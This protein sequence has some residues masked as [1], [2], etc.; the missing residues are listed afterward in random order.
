MGASRKFRPAWRL[1]RLIE[2]TLE[3]WWRF[4]LRKRAEHTGIL[5]KWWSLGWDGRAVMLALAMMAVVGMLWA[6]RSGAAM[7][8]QGQASPGAGIPYGLLC[9]FFVFSWG[10]AAGALTTG[11][12]WLYFFAAPLL[13]GW[14]L[15]ATMANARTPAAI[16]PQLWF[17]AMGFWMA[18]DRAGGRW[19]FFWLGLHVVWVAAVI[20]GPS[21]LRARWGWTT[22][23]MWL[24]LGGCGLALV[25]AW[26]LW[27]H[28]KPAPA[29]GSG[30]PPFLLAWG[31]ATAVFGFCL[32][33]ANARNHA[34][35][36]E[37]VLEL[38][39]SVGFFGD[40][41]WIWI[42]GGFAGSVVGLVTWSSRAAVRGLSLRGVLWA[43]PALVLVVTVAEFVVFFAT[44]YDVA[45]QN[46]VAGLL[47]KENYFA[48]L[49]HGWLGVV[50]LVF[51]LV[52]RLAG[53]LRPRTVLKA[54]VA[55]TAAF[56]LLA[57]TF[58]TAIQIETPKPLIEFSAGGIVI[59]LGIFWETYVLGKEAKS[60]TR[61]QL[62][63]QAA[64]TAV[65]LMVAITGGAVGAVKAGQTKSL[66]MLYGIIHLG[67]LRWFS[68]WWTRNED[69]ETHLTET[70]QAGLFAGG[71]LGCM[72]YLPWQHKSV[73]GL[74]WL[75]PV[76]VAAA[77]ILSHQRR[78]LTAKGAAV[79]GAL[80]AAGI[81]YQWWE[82][83][84]IFYMLLPTYSPDNSFLSAPPYPLVKFNWDHRVMAAL[85]CLAGGAA[86]WLGHRLAQL[87]RSAAPPPATPELRP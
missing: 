83:S 23:D 45:A 55:W 39:E 72:A 74:M 54:V 41:F 80:V 18:R 86:G 52:A 84:P 32:W 8:G 21:G 13:L 9:T 46:R 11:P 40:Y 69:P 81:A 29:G 66:Y 78:R 42:G 7:P 68:Q 6:Q 82:T 43:A 12:L 19:R 76:I 16:L 87:I 2:A 33:L 38:R 49:E 35:T 75:L 25:A 57:A 31:G 10:L 20:G 85:S 17:A 28:R 34:V 58:Q 56:F 22:T 60:I 62:L 79:A 70:L 63:Q 15:L 24:L 1:F 61:T 14:S 71:E 26:A 67:L 65:I 77:A 47:S 4:W 30:R 27:L 3:Y 36:A 53:K 44:S 73:W 50:T 64:W 5:W 37:W 59:F 48:T 51:L